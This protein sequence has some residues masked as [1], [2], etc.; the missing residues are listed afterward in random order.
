[1]NS[2]RSISDGLCPGDFLASIDLSEAYL[3]ITI[4]P[5]HWKYLRFSYM[6]RHLQYRALPFSLA[7]APRCFTKI[8]VALI[9][10]LRS[11][12]VR[13][14]AYLDD[15]LIQ[16]PSLQRAQDDLHLTLQAL[17]ALGLL[18][19]FPKSQLTPETR[20]T[21]LGA[22]IDTRLGKVFLS[23]EKRDNLRLL[24]CQILLEPMVPLVT[25][26][27]LLRKMAS[28]INIVPWAHLHARGFQWFLL[29]HQ[30]T[31][32]SNSLAKVRVPLSVYRSSHW[33]MS[34]ALDMESVFTDTQKFTITTDA[35]LYGWGAHLDSQVAQGR[36]SPVEAH[37]NINFLE[38]RAIQHFHQAVGGCHVLI[39]TDN[40]M[41]K[42]HVN[43]QGGTR[44]KH[45]MQEARHLG[46]WAELHV[47]SLK[48][49]H[50]A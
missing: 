45:L 43:R 39:L 41:V 18:V 8:L 20:L 9:A 14:Q 49:E 26:S 25:L 33:W 12:R 36:W 24:I 27:R 2:L 37:S 3:H 19:N 28:C 6:G 42:A 5:A 48:A 44:S 34:P 11:I 15:I 4:W 50:I 7:S 1:M 38:L 17:Q 32:S 40:I 47:L 31:R 30:R 21:H 35:S 22:I 46:R 13:L 29:P 23:Q 16:A 10:H